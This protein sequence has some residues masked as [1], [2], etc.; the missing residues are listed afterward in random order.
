MAPVS[1]LRSDLHVRRHGL[2]QGPDLLLVHGLTDSGEGW[3]QAIAH[4]GERFRITTLDLRGHGASP[5]F[6]GAQLEAH[7]GDIMVEDVSQVVEQLE[8]PVVLGHSLGGAVALAVAARRPDLV[9]AVVLED[10]APR[11]PEEPQRDPTRGRAYNDGLRPAREAAD[12]DALMMLRR[13]LHPDWPAEELMPTGLAE[14]QTQE[15]YLLHGD[16]K[17]TTPWPELLASL[18][19]PALLVTGGDLDEVVVSPE[20]EEAMRRAAPDHLQVRRLDGAGHCVRRDRQD[21]FY[22]TVDEWLAGLP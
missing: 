18:R 3:G 7:P 21:L 8:Q 5:R 20:L 17:P 4:W 14:Q 11:S 2:G 15:D 10:P 19:V 1:E 22:A 16:W 12:D 13:E 6:T 9:R